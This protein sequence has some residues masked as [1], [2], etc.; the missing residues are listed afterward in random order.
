MSFL[1]R[2]KFAV[3]PAP[4]M[5]KKFYYIS[6]AVFLAIILFIEQCSYVKI[7]SHDKNIIDNGISQLSNFLFH[8]D[9]T[10]PCEELIHEIQLKNYGSLLKMMCYYREHAS[11]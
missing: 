9:Q 1:K 5:L 10:I 2:Y 4:K 3:L 6:L 11:K 7:S 8:I